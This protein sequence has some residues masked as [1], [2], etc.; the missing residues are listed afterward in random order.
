MK[1]K[2]DSR[3]Q[4]FITLIAIAVVLTIVYPYVST[5]GDFTKV[6]SKITSKYTTNPI[7][8]GIVYFSGDYSLKINYNGKKLSGGNI[9]FAKVYRESGAVPNRYDVDDQLYKTFYGSNT[10][11]NIEFVE[12][13]P[14]NYLYVPM[15]Q[16][17]PMLFTYYVV[18]Y[19]G[20][21]PYEFNKTVTIF[22]AYQFKSLYKASNSYNGSTCGTVCDEHCNQILTR[23]K[24]S[25]EVFGDS[26]FQQK[27]STCKKNWFG[28]C[29]GSKTINSWCASGVPQGYVP[30]VNTTNPTDSWDVGVN[31]II[32]GTDRDKTMLF[33]GKEYSIHIFS[34][35]LETINGVTVQA[36]NGT[37][38]GERFL[39]PAGYTTELADGVQIKIVNIAVDEANN[40]NYILIL[41]TA[42]V[43]VCTDSD[44]GTNYLIKGNVKINNEIVCEDKCDANGYVTDCVCT[45]MSWNA[46]YSNTS[47]SGISVG[48]TTTSMNC[49]G[50]YGA[51]AVCQ[52]GACK[53]DCGNGICDNGETCS[54]CSTD[55]G[56][57][58]KSCVSKYAACNTTL[59]CCTNLYCSSGTCKCQTAAQACSSSKPCCSPLNCLHGYCSSSGAQIV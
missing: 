21:E 15:E 22:K 46:S 3:A 11:I 27:S 44:N 51:G 37:I 43:S 45:K 19:S 35:V 30:A 59:N 55:C 10:K 49:N 5:E 6:T 26:C 40:K 17:D 34:I 33:N 57:C 52:N 48:Y 4:F 36:I 9:Y 31:A 50:S 41:F 20:K 25:S 2:F 1:L 39:T 54:S 23:C 53:P 18:I 47:T 58:P 28:Q 16:L 56:A 32:V 14:S 13:Y 12:N 7:V 24:P 38:N 42:P 8:N 29:T